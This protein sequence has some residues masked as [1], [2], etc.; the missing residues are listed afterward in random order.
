M[1]VSGIS[2]SEFARVPARAGT[3]VNPSDED[4]L[5]R[6]AQKDRTAL[7][8]LALR[9][10]AVLHR[11]LCGLMDSPE[12]AEEAVLDVFVRV[13]QHAPRFRHQ[14]QVRTWLYRIALNLA[15]DAHARAAARPRTTSSDDNGA[16]GVAAAAGVTGDAQELALGRLARAEQ[17]RDLRR[18]LGCLSPD[19]RSLLVLYYLEDWEYEQIQSVMNL[20]YTVLKMRLTRARRRLRQVL[21]AQTTEA[22]A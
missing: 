6:C 7:E 12:D 22:S 16:Y 5:R 8:E 3:R 10:Q 11:F 1:S 19:D 18:A 17:A 14:A 2:G 20:S 4:L 13:W 21:E 9:H 15:R